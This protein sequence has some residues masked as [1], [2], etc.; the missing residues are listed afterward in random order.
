MS[1]SSVA[2]EISWVFP[3]I[4][5][6]GLDAIPRIL[7]ISIVTPHVAVFGNGFIIRLKEEEG[8]YNNRM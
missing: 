2:A 5:Y 3:I 1:W 6:N 7:D 4:L 8:K